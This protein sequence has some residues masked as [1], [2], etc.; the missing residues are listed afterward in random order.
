VV[1]VVCLPDCHPGEPLA[2]SRLAWGNL[3]QAGYGQLATG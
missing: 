2:A 3:E 1:T